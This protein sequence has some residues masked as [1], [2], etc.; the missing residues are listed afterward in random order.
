[1]RPD[2]RRAPATNPN[3][4]AIVNHAVSPSVSP[5]SAANSGAA[6]VALNHRDMA[7]SSAS[8]IINNTRCFRDT[9]VGIEW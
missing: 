6:A 7:R 9:I 3:C 8:A 1:V 4:T 2:E 5:H